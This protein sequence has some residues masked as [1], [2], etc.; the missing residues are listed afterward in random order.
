MRKIPLGRP[1]GHGEEKP[2]PFTLGSLWLLERQTLLSSWRLTQDQEGRWKRT[3]RGRVGATV[4]KPAQKRCSC[5]REI[6]D[7]RHSGKQDGPALTQRRGGPKQTPLPPCSRSFVVRLWLPLMPSGPPPPPEVTPTALI[8]FCFAPGLFSTTNF[9]Q[10][11]WRRAGDGG[12]VGAAA[13]QIS[14]LSRGAAGA[15]FSGC[16]G[17]A[18]GKVRYPGPAVASR[19]RSLVE[20]G[21]CTGTAW[22]KTAIAGF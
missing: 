6:R 7:L 15:N 3:R 12:G 11:P 9:Q 13:V 18:L 2:E 5:W 20:S 19:A 17:T 22:P 16:L 14:G 21:L 1:T 4:H 8:I 10:S